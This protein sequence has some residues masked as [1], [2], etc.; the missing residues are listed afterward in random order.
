MDTSGVPV[1][2]LVTSL[3]HRARMPQ[4]L[5]LYI[6]CNCLSDG[7]TRPSSSGMVTAHVSYAPAAR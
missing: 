6:P 7:T 5:L 3:S 2:G 1:I 4:T